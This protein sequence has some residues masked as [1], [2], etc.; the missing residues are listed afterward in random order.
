MRP[1]TGWG[2]GLRGCIFIFINL[3]YLYLYVN[4]YCLYTQLII[5]TL[6]SNVVFLL[7]YFLLYN[8]IFY[9]WKQYLLL[10]IPRAVFIKYGTCS[11]SRETS[12]EA[13]THG[14]SM[15]EHGTKCSKNRRRK[16]PSR[17]RVGRRTFSRR[18]IPS[19][20]PSVFLSAVLVPAVRVAVLPLLFFS[21]GRAVCNITPTDRTC[22]PP[23][24]QT[25]LLS[26]GNQCDTHTLYRHRVVFLTF[27]SPCC[28]SALQGLCRGQFY[29]GRLTHLY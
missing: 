1:S 18:F 5:W 14:G 7:Y 8:L 20:R 28:P 23:S 6:C 11:G 9:S 17:V 25:A 26:S 15:F 13:K 16:F 22:V 19:G 10:C 12:S 3:Y 27:A 29:S 24:V 4:L 21:S 2:V